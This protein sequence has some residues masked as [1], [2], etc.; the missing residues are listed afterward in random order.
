MANMKQSDIVTALGKSKHFVSK[1]CKRDLSDHSNFYDSP[2][3]GAPVTAL[4]PENMAKLAACEGKL[5]QSKTVLRD[6]L[7]ISSGSITNGFKKLCLFAYRRGV[8]SRL[9]KKHVKIRFKTSKIMRHKDVKFWER[10]AITDEKIWTVDGYFNPQNDRVRAKCKEDVESVERDKFPGKRMVWL[11]MSA[12]AL[13]P[14]VH[15]KGSVNGS[16]YQEKV[17]K[18]VILHDVLQ[19]KKT[20]GLPI[21]KRKMFTKNSDMIF[22]QDFAQPHSTNANQQFMEEHF[23]AHT[24]TLWRYEDTDPL[25]F[26]P[27]W[28][29][30]WSIERLWAILSQ[31]VYRNPR[32]THISGFMRRLREEVRNT[33]P[34]T[35]TR[36][37]HE[38]PAKMNEIYR[39]KGKKIPGNFDHRK[40]PHACKCSVCES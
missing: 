15:F 2:R 17:L 11:G 32:P 31:R 27:K 19:R 9:K 33:D 28:D 20:K 35:L 16:V 29:D 6:K 8:Q 4:T 18:K 1:W 23:P 13:T 5:G 39:L 14:L 36:L 40:S 30:F 10:F 21:H 24:P 37:V 26:G 7:G 34:K 22:E 25:F 38:L 12:R 3:K